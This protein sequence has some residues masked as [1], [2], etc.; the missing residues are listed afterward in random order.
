M[1]S[2]G[3]G[4][5]SG[6]RIVEMGGIGPAPFAGMMLADHGAEVI[7]V[8]RPGGG[9]YYSPKDVL[10]R[11]R[12]SLAVN[13]KSVEG[14][15]LVR[16]LC[17]TAD[18][19]IEGFRPGVMERMGL[20][21]D[22]LMNDNPRLVYGRVTG[23]GQGGP[24]AALAGHDINYIA[25][26]GAL[27]ACGRAGEK[28]TVPLNLFGD[29]GG[30]GLM[31]AFGMV[32][33]LL[34]VCTTGKGQVVDCAMIDGVSSLMA[35]IWRFRA[36]GRW[37]DE[38]GLNLL[39]SG[40]HFYDCFETA[41]GKYVSIGAIEPQFYAELRARLG[42]ANDPAFDVQADEAGWPE[43]KKRL[44]AV[45]HTRTRAEWCDMFEGSDACFAPVMSMAEA[46]SHPHL[47]QRGTLIEID[48]IVQPA[49]AP[50]FS[51]TPAA[52][53]IGPPLPGQDSESIMAALG[54]PVAR[55]RQLVDAGVVATA[56]ATISPTK[57]AEGY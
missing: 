14:V 45:F 15:E 35:M 23:W 52:R 13:L 18:G 31:L 4:V 1:A 50:R 3:E 40:A 37:H 22:A 48:D 49:P 19:M 12:R 9:A 17:R 28:P 44:A 11:G 25:I 43:L 41:D 8:D 32:S 51:S 10:N 7:R 47:A 54:Y 46:P 42:I 20:G 16:D 39:D 56:P 30:G 29:F 38:R 33:A 2:V 5:L 26:T 6:L 57:I 27:H 53:P 55:I 24:Y 36:E 21:P 34:N